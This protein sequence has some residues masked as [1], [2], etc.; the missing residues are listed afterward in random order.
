MFL[1]GSD[2]K[3]TMLRTTA[4]LSGSTSKYSECVDSILLI[5]RSNGVVL[6]A[7]EVSCYYFCVGGDAW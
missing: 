7:V 2:N 1:E 6:L 5:L 3:L 4:P